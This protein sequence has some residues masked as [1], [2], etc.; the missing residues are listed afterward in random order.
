[1]ESGIIDP[2]TPALHAEK[3][4]APQAASAFQRHLTDM[5]QDQYDQYLMNLTASIAEQGEKVARHADVAEFLKYREMIRQ[6]MDEVV[7]N[8]YAFA[9]K[10]RF[11]ARGRSRTMAMVQLLNE[12]LDDMLKMVLQDEADHIALLSAVDDIRGMLVDILT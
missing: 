8:G 5:G 9:K 11:D 7:S 4:N 3:V 2:T 1:M 6:L 12:K 10:R